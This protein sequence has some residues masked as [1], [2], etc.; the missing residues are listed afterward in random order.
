[1]KNNTRPMSPRKIAAN[2]L[3]LP[4]R[5]LLCGGYAVVVD[6]LVA[7]VV[8]TSGETHELPRMEFYGGLLVDAAACDGVDWRPGDD[9]L[10]RLAERYALGPTG[11]LALIEGADFARF[12]WLSTT[13]LTRL[14]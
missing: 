14:R 11:T 7:E 4:G 9:I 1:M 5:P 6:G 8:D 2:Y 13:R 10:A 12:L 3:F